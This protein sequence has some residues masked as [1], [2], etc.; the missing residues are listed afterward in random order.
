MNE[1]EPLKTSQETWRN[2]LISWFLHII[3]E[4]GEIDQ[5]KDLYINARIS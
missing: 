2:E 3:Q 5:L 4:A 1:Y